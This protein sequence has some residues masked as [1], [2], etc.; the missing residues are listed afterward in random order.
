MLADDA[1][2]WQIPADLGITTPTISATWRC[3]SPAPR[4]WS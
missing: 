4:L 2:Y 1:T 3:V